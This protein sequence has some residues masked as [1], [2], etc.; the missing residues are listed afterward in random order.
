ME[1]LIEMIEAQ[2]KGH[3]NDDVFT[4]GEQLKDMARREPAI[5]E[6]LTQ[7]LQVPEMSLDGAAKKL[8][9]YADKNHGKANRFCITPMV[10]EGILRKF[11]GLPKREAGKV[12]ELAPSVTNS[13]PKLDLS[14]FL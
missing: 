13:V 14:D 5:V 7:D 9:E 10:A 8:Q 3:E 6:L 1:K 11:Y 2:Q 12:Q 4:V